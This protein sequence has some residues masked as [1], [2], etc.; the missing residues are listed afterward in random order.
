MCGASQICDH[1]VGRLTRQREH[2]VG[3]DRNESTIYEQHQRPLRFLTYLLAGLGI[4]PSKWTSDGSADTTASGMQYAALDVTGMIVDHMSAHA[5]ESTFI[6][7]D[8]FHLVDTSPGVL[9]SLS[10]IIRSLPPNW[11]V[12]ISSRRR[13]PLA[14]DSLSLGGRV[15]KIQGRQL[16]LT[17]RE[18]A[19]WTAHNWNLELQTAEARA[20]W[21]LTEG[22]PAALVLLGRRLLS[23]AGSIGH[24]TLAAALAQGGELQH[25]L[26][27]DILGGLEPLAAETMMTAA[28]L[29]RVVFPRDEELLPGAPGT[30]EALLEEFVLEG[31][32]VTRNGRRTYTIHP[33]VREFVLRDA[34]TIDRT[35]RLDFAAPPPRPLRRRVSPDPGVDDGTTRF[36]HDSGAGGLAGFYTRRRCRRA[37]AFPL[38]ACCKGSDTAEAG[39][40]RGGHHALRRGGGGSR[41]LG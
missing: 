5:G 28:L 31:F 11:T 18:V 24:E 34:G 37:A 22:W 35:G 2:D 39:R 10:L 14:L 21:R 25:Y 9:S 20:L 36:F 30:A 29:P 3:V 40:L 23:T 4:A 17:P 26:E 19:A 8:D 6:A 27:Q 16:R 38:A 41:F 12:L 33:L 13:V 15:T 1:I 7:I 32:L